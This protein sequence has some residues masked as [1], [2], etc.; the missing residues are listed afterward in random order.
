MSKEKSE[1]HLNYFIRPVNMNVCTVG[2]PKYYG[3]TEPNLLYSFI[4]IF[5]FGQ[6]LATNIVIP[7]AASV[8]TNESSNNQNL[9]VCVQF[10][11]PHF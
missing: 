7:G 5:Q 10:L 8:A 1:D 11:S 9:T 3:H 6:K 2:S 4:D